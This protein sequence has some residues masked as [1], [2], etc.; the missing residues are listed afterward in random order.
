MSLEAGTVPWD[1]S[2]QMGIVPFALFL[3]SLCFINL[4]TFLSDVMFIFE[5]A[6]TKKLVFK[7]L[8][9][10]VHYF[11]IISDYLKYNQKRPKTILSIVFFGSISNLES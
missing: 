8:V 1:L 5:K 9:Y 7:T 10:Y 11:L 4:F 6:Y 3:F 2:P